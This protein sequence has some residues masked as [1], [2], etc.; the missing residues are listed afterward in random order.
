MKTN[1]YSIPIKMKGF[2]SLSA[3]KAHR[4]VVGK[5]TG[6]REAAA[7]VSQDL[8]SIDKVEVEAESSEPFKDLAAGKGKVIALAESESQGLEGFELDYDPASG[9][10]RRFEAD[11]HNGNLTQ[12]GGTFRWETKD[13]TNPSTTLFSFDDK[14]GIITV[15]DPNNQIPAIFEGTNPDEIT[16]D[17]KLILTTSPLLITDFKD[18]DPALLRKIG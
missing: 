16:K 12:N 8:M 13:E 5:L 10:V 9:R 15:E 14:R 4:K 2:S 7:D 6:L 17:S 18:I 3:A 11:L 1:R